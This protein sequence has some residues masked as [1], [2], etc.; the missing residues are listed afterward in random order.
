[1]STRRDKWVV[2]VM[3]LVLNY[4]AKTELKSNLANKGTTK[5]K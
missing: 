3:G 2:N 4:S 1:M 5:A